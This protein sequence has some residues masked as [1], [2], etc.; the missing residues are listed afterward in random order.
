MP[1]PT[2]LF[3]SLFPSGIGL[4]LLAYGRRQNRWPHI[5]AGLIYLVYPYFATTIWSLVGIGAA[6]GVALWY[7]VREG[8]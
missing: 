7:A 4:V 6:V 3:L 5:V 1:D 8:W 2:W